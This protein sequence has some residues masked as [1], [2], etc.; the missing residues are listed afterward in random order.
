MGETQLLDQRLDPVGF[1]DRVEVLPLQVLDQ[2]EHQALLSPVLADDGGDPLQARHP[3]R[4]PAPLAGD[5]LI[6][7]R[8]T[9]DE[10]GLDDPV[11]ADRVGQLTEPLGGE[12]LPHLPG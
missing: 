2:A 1:F 9:P 7:L 5:Q 12:L 10:D 6:P 8:K 3:G 4:A 11:L